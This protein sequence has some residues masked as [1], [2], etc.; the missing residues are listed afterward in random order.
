MHTFMLSNGAK[1]VFVRQPQSQAGAVLFLFKV[2]SVNETPR[3]RGISHFMEHMIFKGTKKRPNALA[4]SAELDQL[5]GDY[6]AFTSKEHTCFHAKVIDYHLPLVIDILSDIFLNSLFDQKEI[7]RERAV[8]LQEICMVEDTPDD[9][10]HIL[11]SESFW[12]GHSLARPIYGYPDTVQSFNKEKIRQY[13]GKHYHPR[14]IVIAA[15]GNVDH[16][17]LI[18]LLEDSFGKLSVKPNSYTRSSPSAHPGVHCT[19]KELEQIHICLATPTC[20]F[21]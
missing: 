20:S 4:I 9:Y 1:V 2:G 5:G 12:Q 13:M 16:Q 3:L 14:R 6:N 8:I 17:G 7:E 21:L 15:A 18:R 11:L 10:I 19:S